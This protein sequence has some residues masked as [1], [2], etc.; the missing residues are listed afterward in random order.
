M[1]SSGQAFNSRESRFDYVMAQFQWLAKAGQWRR[2]SEYRLTL[3]WLV[4][5][6]KSSSVW[7]IR[8]M[9]NMCIAAG[10]NDGHL[11]TITEP[12]TI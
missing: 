10:N 8:Q 9:T 3:L 11:A 2:S 5:R 6:L 4:R 7:T 1:D 12:K